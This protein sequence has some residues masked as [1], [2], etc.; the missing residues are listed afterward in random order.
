MEND[1]AALRNENFEDF[2]FDWV[3]VTQ[4]RL[5]EIQYD[6][7][8]KTTDNAYQRIASLRDSEH[9]VYRPAPKDFPMIGF[10]TSSKTWSNAKSTQNDKAIEFSCLGAQK[11][12]TKLAECFCEKGSSSSVN[13]NSLHETPTLVLLKNRDVDVR[14]SDEVD[15]M[16]FNMKVIIK[17]EVLSDREALFEEMSGYIRTNQLLNELK[18]R[19]KCR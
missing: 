2:A 3:Y 7:R 9:R 14:L 6:D 19:G 4:G 1:I 13:E 15:L 18:R 5:P 11:F 12:L 17:Q 10:A 16:F 8:F